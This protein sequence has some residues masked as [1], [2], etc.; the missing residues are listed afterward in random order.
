MQYRLDT[1]KLNDKE[2]IELEHMRDLGF[3]YIARHEIGRVELF[4]EKPERKSY[5]IGVYDI[6]GIGVY[7]VQNLKLCRETKLNYDFITW[8]NGTW[9]I[10]EILNNIK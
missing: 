2:I 5:P 7:P 6:W 10:E 4:K 1:N 9:K 8:D 3:K